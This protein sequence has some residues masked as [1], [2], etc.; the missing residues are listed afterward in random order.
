MTIL[1]GDRLACPWCDHVPSGEGRDRVLEICEADEL[2]AVSLVRDAQ[3]D[4]RVRLEEDPDYETR[5]DADPRLI[6]PRC[7]RTFQIP[8]EVD[9]L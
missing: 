4:L 3:G 7:A 9:Y 1:T 2:S 8:E 5:D 6:C